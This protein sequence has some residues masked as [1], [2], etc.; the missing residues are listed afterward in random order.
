MDPDRGTFAM[1]WVRQSAARARSL[2]AKGGRSLGSPARLAGVA[3]RIQDGRRGERLVFAAVGQRP[4]SG[5][6]P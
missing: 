6:E 1:T 3:N 2:R 4:Q 5:R